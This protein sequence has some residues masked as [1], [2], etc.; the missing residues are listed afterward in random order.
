M[1]VALSKNCEKH[2]KKY[3]NATV[4]LGVDEPCK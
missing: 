2:F 1:E 3:T 4:F